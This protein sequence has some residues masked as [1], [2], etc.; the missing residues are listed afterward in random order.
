MTEVLLFYPQV[1]RNKLSDYV[2]TLGY[3]SLTLCAA[4]KEGVI[5]DSSLSFESY[6]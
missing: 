1:A 3:L 4:V 5:S 2:V 6:V